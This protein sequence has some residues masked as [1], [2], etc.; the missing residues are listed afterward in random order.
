MAIN[1]NIG[2]SVDNV[3]SFTGEHI[4]Q[5]VMISNGHMSFAMMNYGDINFASDY[6]KEYYAQVRQKT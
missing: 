6:D 4:P 5:I 2:T 1:L 3:I